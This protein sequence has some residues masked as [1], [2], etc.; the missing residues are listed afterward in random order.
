MAAMVVSVTAFRAATGQSNSALDYHLQPVAAASGLQQFS[1][2]QVAVLEKLNRADR[3]HLPRLGRIVVPNRWAADERSYS[4]LPVS[5]GSASAVPKS[6]VVM[7]DIQAFGAYEYGTLVRWGPVST[8]SRGRET[9]PGRLSLNWKSPGRSST[10]NPEWYMP[11]YF[12]VRNDQG[13][14]FHAYALPGRPASHGCIRLLE[15]DAFWLFSWG[16]EWTLDEG[17]VRTHGTPVLL[18][19]RYDFTAGPPWANV[20]TLGRPLA[21]PDY[22]R[23]DD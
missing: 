21:L 14:A 15:R 1:E 5:Y 19:G 13:V 18:N 20:E 7:I 4:P 9:A 11:W 17:R 10:V 8:G 23:D 12:N 22:S 3:D 6:L 2:E 16:E